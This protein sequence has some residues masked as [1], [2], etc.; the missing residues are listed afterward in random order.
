MLRFKLEALPTEPNLTIIKLDFANDVEWT[1]YIGMVFG[2]L[3]VFQARLFDLPFADYLRMCRDTYGAT[4]RG[5]TGYSYAVWD[6]DTKVGLL[7]NELNSR[8][9][10]ALVKI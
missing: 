1:A 10:K 2:S 3:N 8:L 7:L 5:N 6:K 9:T 4:L